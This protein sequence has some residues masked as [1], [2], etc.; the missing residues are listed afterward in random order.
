MAISKIFYL[1]EKKKSGER[2]NYLFNSIRYILNSQKTENGRFVS[3]VNCIPEMAGKQMVDTKRK[4]GK[5]NGRQ[6]YH[7][8]ISFPKDFQDKILA[9]SIIQQFTTEYLGKEYEAVYALHTDQEHLHGHIVFN[10]VKMTGNSLSK[11]WK[12]R[13]ENGDWEKYIQPIVDRLCVENGLKP[14]EF[15]VS[16][17]KRSNMGRHVKHSKTFERMLEE[18]ISKEESLS[19]DG[20]SGRIKR[21]VDEAIRLANSYSEFLQILKNK[22]EI[23]E[24]KYLSLKS[25]DMQR[26]RRL[27]KEGRQGTIDSLSSGY[28]IEE[29]KRRILTENTEDKSKLESASS[30]GKESIEGVAYH[31]TKRL[32][33]SGNETTTNS[34]DRK[35]NKVWDKRRQGEFCWCRMI[36]YDIDS[37][38]TI[39]Y[40]YRDFIDRLKELGYEVRPGRNFLLK[41]PGM[42]RFIKVSQIGPDYEDRMLRQR[43]E[44]SNKDNIVFPYAM[45]PPKIEVDKVKLSYPVRRYHTLTRFEKL[46]L[47]QLYRLGIIK[48]SSY[49]KYSKYK[50]QIKE[51]HQLQEEYLLIHRYGLAS[52]SEINHLHEDLAQ[53][54][55]QLCKDRNEIYQRKRNNQVILTLY[56][57]MKKIQV[58]YELHNAG[59]DTFIEDAKLYVEDQQRMRRLGYTFEEVEKLHKDIHSSINTIGKELTA[60]RK[61]ESICKRLI[62]KEQEKQERI[63]LEK[64]N[65]YSSKI[66]K[67]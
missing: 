29:I 21:D 30:I 58:A 63:E 32:S 53:K 26:A 31:A 44:S 28:S 39:S 65:G 20:L 36:S 10:S 47:S 48:H 49:S 52:G 25:D 35:Q 27:G 54:R 8:V 43:I 4:Y 22:Y 12:Y 66:L 3:A 56:E 40:S 17:E 55:I 41:G 18:D 60:V 59:D 51:L 23:K 13:Y 14:L 46:R 16:E 37:S 24:G 6:G 2:H 33:H 15:Y 42:Y 67:K 57:E 61:E 34:Y 9:F 50:Q 19:G 1:S 62:R 7:M 64:E 5:L 45:K 11:Y 38:I